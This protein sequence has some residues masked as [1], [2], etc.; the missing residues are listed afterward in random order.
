MGIASLVIAIAAAVLFLLSL[1]PFVGWLNVIVIPLAFIG[2][3]LGLIGL[4]FAFS[5]SAAQ[6][7]LIVNIIL[8]VLAFIVLF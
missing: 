6:I 7:G 4:R 2:L 1:I 3:V 5:K 8:L